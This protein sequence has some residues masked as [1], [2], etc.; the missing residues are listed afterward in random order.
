MRIFA[1][2][3]PLIKPEDN[4]SDMLLHAIRKLG[5]KLE[6]MDIIAV[7]SKAVATTQGRTIR[8]E[9]VSPSKEARIL[10]ENHSLEPQFAELVLRE[11]EKIYGGVEKAILT[12]KYGILTV[13][14]GIDQK[15]CPSGQA[16]LWP[17]NPQQSAVALR[18]EIRRRTGKNVGILIVDSE[19]AP[20]R[21][22]TRGIALAVSG[23]NSVRDC[24]SEKDLFQKP[25]SITRHAIADDLAS[26]AHLLMGETNKRTPFVLIRDAPVTLTFE[27]ASAERMQIPFDQCVYAS[28]FKIQPP[29]S[30]P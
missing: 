27:K 12:L 5:L 23:F 20:L 30:K 7:A 19:V 2:K 26:A 11:A 18:S 29:I 24:R 3:T 14:A 25:L 13:N 9:E 21:M 1:I 22:G 16:V 17:C 6:N 10:A 15:N 8:L 4:L 28:A